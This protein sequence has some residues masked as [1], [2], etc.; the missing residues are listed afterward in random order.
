MHVGRGIALQNPDDLG[1]DGEIIAAE[2]ALADRAEASGFESLWVAE[3]H[4]TD[5]HLC[6]SPLQILTYLAG[7][8]SR[9]RLGS[10]VVVL[11]WHDPIRVAEDLS[12][13]DHLSGGRVVLGVGRGL[14]RVEFDGF[15]L[16]MSESRDRFR[17]YAQMLIEAFDT[18]IM[19]SDGPLYVQ[20]PTP[21]RP[22]PL[23]S[24]RGRTYASAVSAS[25]MELMAQLGF[26]I[27]VI[28]QKPWNITLSEVADYRERFVSINGHEPPR[29]LLVSYV[30]VHESEG[31]AQE[32]YERYNK[33][34]ARTCVEHYEFDN[35]KLGDVP[36]Y[37]Y[38]GGIAR[39][40]AKHGVEGFVKFLAD[41]HVH[42]TPAQVAEQ[43]ID[44]VRL[45][46]GAGVI[47]ALSFGGMP[48]E[49]AARNQELFVREVLPLLKDV[50]SHRVLPDPALRVPV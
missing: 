45:L 10:M 34:Y 31:G 32:M 13:L 30:S 27:M 3:H 36:G 12:M 8:T 49:E 22:R 39:N 9:L 35:L 37:E 17:E 25:S 19:R 29:P 33:G 41:L 43:L 20:P 46:D 38:Y 7:R 23:A 26:G 24:L 6:P 11:P 15:Q 21:L 48:A 14:G 42:G 4:F 28:A 16:Q 2:L 44:H 40:I 5:Y 47:V 50:D 1:T 18:G